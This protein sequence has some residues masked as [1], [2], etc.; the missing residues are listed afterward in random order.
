MVNKKWILAG[1]INMAKNKG[2]ELLVQQEV[3][4][5]YASWKTKIDNVE[6]E[7]DKSKFYMR[8]LVLDCVTITLG[9]IGME[10]DEISN[11]R[12]IYEQVEHEIAQTI[13]LDKDDEELWFSLGKIDDEIKKYINPS[14]YVPS[15]ERYHYVETK[16]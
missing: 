16:I 7:K 11:F 9:V 6:L 13:D 3:S 5:V 8:Q 10:P 15:G 2:F 4:R 12:D 1:D 14:D